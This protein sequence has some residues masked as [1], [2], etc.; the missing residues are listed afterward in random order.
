MKTCIGLHKEEKLP[1]IVAKDDGNG[2][3]TNHED[4]DDNKDIEDIDIGEE[5]NAGNVY[6]QFAMCVFPTSQCLVLTYT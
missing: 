1:S 3:A 6:F 2:E 4:V 5:Q